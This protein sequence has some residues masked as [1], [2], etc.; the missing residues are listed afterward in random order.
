MNNKRVKLKAKD[1]IDYAHFM[2]AKTVEEA[3]RYTDIEP[4]VVTWDTTLYYWGA[5]N[6]GI[7]AS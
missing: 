1:I 4:M 6:K 3:M 2:N 5:F 7:K